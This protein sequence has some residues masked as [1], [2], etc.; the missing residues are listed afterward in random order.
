MIVST[1]RHNEKDLVSLSCSG[2]RNTL[3]RLQLETRFARVEIRNSKIL[4]SR[5]VWIGAAEE[6]NRGSQRLTVDRKKICS[7]FLPFSP[8][9]HFPL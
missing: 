9:F 2:T 1:A 6:W 4:T 3:C 5:G 8:I 7:C